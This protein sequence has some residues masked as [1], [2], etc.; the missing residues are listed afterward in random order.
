MN[1]GFS[2]TLEKED[3][4]NYMKLS[5][6]EKLNWLEEIVLFTEKALTPKGKKVREHFRNNGEIT[7][8]GRE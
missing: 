3:I 5:T 4:L 8:Y 1:K 7:K 6:K 2:Y